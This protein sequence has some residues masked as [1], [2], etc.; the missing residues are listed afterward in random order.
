MNVKKVWSRLVVRRALLM[1]PFCVLIGAVVD[2][3][4]TFCDN[5]FLQDVDQEG[6]AV[7]A[8]T[9]LI[10][11]F[12]TTR[13]FLAFFYPFCLW[14]IRS[15]TP[16]FSQACRVEWA[17]AAGRLILVVL[18]TLLM[19]NIIA[20]ELVSEPTQTTLYNVYSW[21]GVFTDLINCLV[22][23]LLLDGMRALLPGKE[24]AAFRRT[25]RIFQCFW[26][27]LNL[28]ENFIFAGCFLVF[29]ESIPDWFRTLL[30]F[31]DNHPWVDFLLQ[32]MTL[33]AS[34]FLLIGGRKINRSCENLK[35]LDKIINI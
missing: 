20:M 13:V 12:F 1:I 5:I 4:S 2:I 6:Y 15:L 34:I 18:Y 30:S 35:D 3:V 19:G 26:I 8:V 16:R 28:Y 9:V 31:H 33:I 32:T 22:I 21:T 11:F 7:T 29:V 10:T 14:G 27:L 23:F 24:N 25:V 17:E